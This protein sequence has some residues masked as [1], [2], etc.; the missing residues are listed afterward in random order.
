MGDLA[1][2]PDQGVVATD[3]APVGGERASSRQLHHELTQSADAPDAPDIDFRSDIVTLGQIKQKIGNYAEAEELFRSALEKVELDGEP[4][5]PAIVPALSGLIANRIL[6]G[7]LDGT[8]SLVERLLSVAE[9]VGDDPDIV[10]VLNDL[11]R[12]C[13]SESAYELAEPLLVCLLDIKRSKGEDR[14]EVATVLASLAVVRQ[15]LGQHESSEQLWRQVV[16]IRERTLAPNHFAITSALEHLAAA[17]AARGKVG[18]ALQ[19]FQRAHTLRAL[20]LGA[21]HRSL[22]FSRERIADLQLQA[23]ELADLEPGTKSA[24]PR[25][26]NR[27]A[28]PERHDFTASTAAP[29]DTNGAAYISKSAPP[30]EREVSRLPTMESPA[31]RLAIVIATRDVAFSRRADVLYRGLI[32]SVRHAFDIEEEDSLINRATAMI[33]AAREWLFK[34]YKAVLAGLGVITLVLVAQAASSRGTRDRDLKTFDASSVRR[35]LPLAGRVPSRTVSASPV[36][37]MTASKVAGITET[38]PGTPTAAPETP[39]KEVAGDAKVATRR[40]EARGESARAKKERKATED[41]AEVSIPTPCRKSS[42]VGRTCV[43]KDIAARVDSIARAAAAL[44]LT[45]PEN[46]VVEPPFSS[47]KPQRPSPDYL[48]AA[49][50]P[51]GPRLIG[52]LP[53]IRYPIQATDMDGEVRVRFNVDTNGRPVM[54]TFSVIKSTHPLFTAAVRRAISGMRFQPAMSGGVEPKPVVDAVEIPFLFK[55]PI[56]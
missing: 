15:A 55:R 25:E 6:R 51:V 46:Q 35:E 32:S 4:D 20:T 17:C 23:Q 21:E 33:A 5:D 2:H 14:P 56:Q 39:V 18:E 13:L 53:T 42:S 27:L 54:S 41:R 43:A 3:P 8:E 45:A 44:T 40:S 49:A 30:L 26:A 7:S 31:R 47:Q 24:S 36:T 34:R 22:R 9:N 11:V 12:L 16:E 29:S 52:S 37:A 48:A 19:L 50:L 38:K 1:S 10:L 28:S